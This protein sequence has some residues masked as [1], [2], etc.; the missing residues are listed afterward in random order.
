MGCSALIA[1]HDNIFNRSVLAQDGFYFSDALGVSGLL[2]TPVSDAARAA[3]V[4]ANLQKIKDL[5]NWPSITDSYE[6]ALLRA[7]QEK[8]HT[9]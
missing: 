8:K 3:C 9:P 7:V 1:A 6:K 4:Q 5:Y 2:Q